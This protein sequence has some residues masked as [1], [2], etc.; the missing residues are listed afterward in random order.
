MFFFKKVK[1][2]NPD[3][4]CIDYRCIDCEKTK[5]NIDSFKYIESINFRYVIYR[6]IGIILVVGIIGPFLVQ[7]ILPFFL[8]EKHA[9]DSLELWNQYVSLILGLVALLMSIVS[10]Y[11]GFKSS[12]ESY[13]TERR[14][15]DLFHAIQ[16]SL[17]EIIFNVKEIKENTASRNNSSVSVSGD[18]NKGNSGGGPNSGTEERNLKTLDDQ[19]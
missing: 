15:R 14:T 4:K 2:K 9:I 18:N 17:N 12:E 5:I 16:N 3:Y 10:M 8:T 19:K 13:E 1:I 7:C 6:A 11:L